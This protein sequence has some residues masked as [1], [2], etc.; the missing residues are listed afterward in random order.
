MQVQFLNEPRLQPVGLR[1]EWL[2]ID[3]FHVR[4]DN[5]DPA[6]TPLSLVVP[7][8]FSTDLASVPRLP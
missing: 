2:L 8:G 3:P 6:D 7:K 5:G 1:D 4:I